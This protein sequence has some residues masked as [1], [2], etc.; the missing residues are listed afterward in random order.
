MSTPSITT[1]TDRGSAGA[2]HDPSLA[3]G[4]RSRAA[5]RRMVR[6][7]E[8]DPAWSRPLLS[9]IG[10]LAGNPDPLLVLCEIAA[11]WALV[12]A[13]ESGRTR[14]LLLC[15]LSWDSPST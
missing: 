4:E 12:R 13:L 10:L 3:L 7:R 1:P 5:L 2:P 14:H 9:L 8:A 15:G 6:G 11:A